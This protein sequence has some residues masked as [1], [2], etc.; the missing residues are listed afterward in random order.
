MSWLTKTWWVLV[1]AAG[2]LLGVALTIL[3][4]PPAIAMACGG[5]HV[6]PYEIAGDHVAGSFR[7]LRRWGERD[8]PRR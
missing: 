7:G 1:A 3:Y 6:G 4:E 2:P 8:G 5:S